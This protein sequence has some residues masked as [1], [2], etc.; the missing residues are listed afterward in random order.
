M[1]VGGEVCKAGSHV[2][3]NKPASEEGRYHSHGV[4]RCG[5]SQRT[6]CAFSAV[7]GG[8]T[9]AAERVGRWSR[10]ASILRREEHAGCWWGDA[11]EGGYSSSSSK[12]SKECSN[13]YVHG[14]ARRALIPRNSSAPTRKCIRHTNRNCALS[15]L[16]CVID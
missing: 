3:T 13:P 2:P 8:A 6:D 4:R 12:S 1:Y 10:R 16:D 14:V 5:Q 7:V 15:V 9:S 11:G